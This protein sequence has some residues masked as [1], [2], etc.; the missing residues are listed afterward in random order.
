MPGSLASPHFTP[1]RSATA[2]FDRIPPKRSQDRD[3]RERTGH[4]IDAS[5]GAQVPLLT[6]CLAELRHI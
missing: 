2:Q 6:R 4:D 1:T 3:R 5:V